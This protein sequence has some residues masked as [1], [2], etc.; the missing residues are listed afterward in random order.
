MANKKTPDEK[1]DELLEKMRRQSSEAQTAMREIKNSREAINTILAKLKEKDNDAAKI[2]VGNLKNIAATAEE[3]AAI[4]AK[5]YETIS[6]HYTDATEFYN[7]LFVDVKETETKKGKMS[8]KTQLENILQ[9]QKE[10][11]KN[12]EEESD[13]LKKEIENLLKG[14]SSV[15]LAKNFADTKKELENSHLLWFGF[16][17]SLG[18]ILTIHF[19][20]IGLMTAFA[21]S[22]F[23]DTSLNPNSI[24]I[25]VAQWDELLLKLPMSAP[26]IWIAW[27]CQRTISDK[28]KLSEIYNHKANIM[29][30]YTGFS[31]AI[32]EKERN[33]LLTTGTIKEALKNPADQLQAVSTPLA[34]LNPLAKQPQNNIKTKSEKDKK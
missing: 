24:S 5:N 15:A 26:L 31:N 8:I 33:N 18:L 28:R 9:N 27:Y 25:S 23:Q 14:A 20:P 22:L 32:N 21:I 6:G 16:I 11:T 2:K 12:W 19:V 29:K 7:E 3:K 1:I 17:G 13:K 4:I 30:L 34:E 10:S